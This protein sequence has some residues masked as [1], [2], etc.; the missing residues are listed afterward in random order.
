MDGTGLFC[1]LDSKRY[2]STAAR[3]GPGPLALIGHGRDIKVEPWQIIFTM[4]QLLYHLKVI[5]LAQRK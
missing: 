1:Y 3:Y 4:A 5:F 2:I